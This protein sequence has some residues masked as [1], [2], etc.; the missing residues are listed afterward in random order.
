MRLTSALLG[1]LVILV[2][3]CELRKERMFRRSEFLMDTIVTITV[4]SGSKGK[5]DEAIGKAFGELERLE[6][7]LDFFSP[8]SEISE[9]NREASAAPVR[10]SQE[11]FDLLER[12]LE[13]SEKTDGAFDITVGAVVSLYDFQGKKSPPAGLI[14]ER[15]PLVDY[16]NVILDRETMTVKLAREGMLIDPGGITKGYAADRAVEVLRS[17]G[18]RAALVAVAGDIRGYGSKPDGSP[19][20]IGIRDPRGKGREDVIATVEL[21]DMAISTSG[22]YERFFIQDGKRIHHLIDPRTGYP[23]R[24]V[25]SATVLAPLAVYTDSLATALFISGVERGLEIA[26]TLGFDALIIDDEG[27]YHMTESLRGRV[28]FTKGAV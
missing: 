24:G 19:W 2:S 13:V 21:K 6:G 18:I 16:R 15:L 10:V 23:A 9:I 17:E 14:R 11:T 7:L 12:A 25:I 1:L 27:G 20:K 5:A 22:D 26:E 4:V 28:E 8:A 3:S